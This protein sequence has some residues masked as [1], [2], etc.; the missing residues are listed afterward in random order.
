M[1]NPGLSDGSLARLRRNEGVKNDADSGQ[2]VNKAGRRAS[3][4]DLQLHSPSQDA[5]NRASDRSHWGRGVES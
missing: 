4:R 5:G 1:L 2:Q 3:L